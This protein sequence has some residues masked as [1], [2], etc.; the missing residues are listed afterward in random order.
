MS[1]LE[2]YCTSPD[3]VLPLQTYIS[4]TA[5]KLQEIPPGTEHPHEYYQCFLE[6]TKLIDSLFES[7][8]CYIIAFIKEH[9]TTD[10]KI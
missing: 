10:K 7:I 1:Q 6:Y 4:K 3:F 8:F 5:L 2:D 9:N